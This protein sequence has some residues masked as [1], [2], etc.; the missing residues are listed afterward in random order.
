V[1]N[2]REIWR[3]VVLIVGIELAGYL[4]Y[5]MFGQ[6]AGTILG[7]VLGG[8]ISSM[9]TTVSYARR[10]KSAPD[11]AALAA[12]VIMIAS[13][14]AFARVIVEVAVVA[15][16]ILG[17][18]APPLGA[19][20]VLMAL[21]SAGASFLSRGARDELPEQENSAELKSALIF[22]AIYAVV[23]FAVAAAQDYS[24]QADC[25]W[26]RCSRI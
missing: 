3:V 18:V 12:V 6:K 7:G 21:I 9:A 20:C 1:F 24:A 10:A 13:T 5:K 8:L 17:R 23:I 2:P 19:M 26:S 4:A 25:M 11:A 14:I 15:P 22:G 16:G